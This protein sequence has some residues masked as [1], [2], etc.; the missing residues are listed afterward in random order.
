MALWQAR[1]VCPDITFV[2]SRMDLYL[3]FSKMTHE[4][5]W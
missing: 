5:I 2:P 3:R 4:I 1:Q